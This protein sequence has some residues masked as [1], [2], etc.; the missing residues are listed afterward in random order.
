MSL[1]DIRMLRTKKR[2]RPGRSA[3]GQTAIT[4]KTSNQ[5]G[6]ELLRDNTGE[7]SEHGVMP[8]SQTENDFP[9]CFI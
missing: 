5:D 6:I 8:S 3:G 4:L 1:K 2:G 9:P 7:S